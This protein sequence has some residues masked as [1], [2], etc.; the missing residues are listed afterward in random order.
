MYKIRLLYLF[1]YDFMV[2]I[3]NKQLLLLY[4]Y[5]SHLV[6]NNLLEQDETVIK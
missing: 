4:Y 1:K 3:H 5:C 6:A 2:A